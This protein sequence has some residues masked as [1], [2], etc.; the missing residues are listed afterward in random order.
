MPED[1]DETA[2]SEITI[3]PDGRVY[4]LGASQQVLQTLEVIS[5]NDAVLK[6]RLGHI[7][8]LEASAANREGGRG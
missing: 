6:Q 4:V 8:A 3:L 1:D 5:P 7:R 2:I